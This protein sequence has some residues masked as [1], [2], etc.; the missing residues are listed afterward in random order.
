MTL[1][2]EIR[3][4]FDEFDPPLLLSAAVA[5][6]KSVIDEA[7][8]VP[9]LVPLMD[10]WHIMA[11]DY[12]GAWENFTHHNAPLCGY[13]LDEGEFRTFNAV[14]GGIRFLETPI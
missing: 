9:Q 10:K 6:G 5:A 12:H 4:S 3:K 7:Y 14:S 8:D 2:Q 13:Y 11:Y 1:M